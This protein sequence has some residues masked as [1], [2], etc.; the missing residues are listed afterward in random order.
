MSEPLDLPRNIPQGIQEAV[1]RLEQVRQASLES[2]NSIQHI[3]QEVL[4][5][6]IV[7][8]DSQTNITNIHHPKRQ[9]SRSNDTPSKRR[10][11]LSE[12]DPNASRALT[13]A[14]VSRSGRKRTATIKGSENFCLRD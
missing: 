12:K 11:P 7:I 14:P 8:P 6:Q 5:S 10:A 4:E 1:D 2:L 13:F 3:A 9:G